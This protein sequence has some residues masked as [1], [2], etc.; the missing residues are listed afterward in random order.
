MQTN[1]VYFYHIN[2]NSNINKNIYNNIHAHGVC[3]RRM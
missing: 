3:M 2:V 1:D